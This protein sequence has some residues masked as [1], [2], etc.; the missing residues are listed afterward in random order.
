FV[1]NSFP[2]STVNFLAGSNT[3]AITINVSGDTAIEPDETFTVTLS[4]PSPGAV[5]GTPISSVGT[6]A[7]DDTGIAIQTTGVTHPEGNS[8]PTPFAF[9]ITRTGNLSGTTN[10]TYTVTG[11]APNP[12]VASDFVG[13]SLPSST[14]NF[15]SNVATRT[16]T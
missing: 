6:I 5:L 12:A 7:N 15:G 2:A 16:I 1:G 14:I 9:I 4:N 3:A 8:G 13:G 10:I 11:S